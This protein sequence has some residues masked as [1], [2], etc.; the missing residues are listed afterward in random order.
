MPNWMKYDILI[1]AVSHIKAK[2]HV[3]EINYTIK[4][5]INKYW[6]IVYKEMIF[7]ILIQAINTI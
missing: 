1:S 3:I 5:F 7:A 4:S 6:K 2:S